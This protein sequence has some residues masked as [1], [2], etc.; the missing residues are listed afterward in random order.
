MRT[1]MNFWKCRLEMMMRVYLYGI[2]VGFMFVI[3]GGYA[4]KNVFAIHSLAF[5]SLLIGY[6]SI[7]L[8]FLLIQ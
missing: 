3:A 8:L 1:I 2:M 5:I 6:I 7:S 4:L